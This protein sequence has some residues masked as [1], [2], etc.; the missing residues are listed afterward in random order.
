MLFCEALDHH[1]KCPGPRVE[2]KAKLDIFG[3][4]D[5]HAAAATQVTLDSCLLVP[6]LHRGGTQILAQTRKGKKTPGKEKRL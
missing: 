4:E 6:Q 1:G 3:V 5:T 2:I